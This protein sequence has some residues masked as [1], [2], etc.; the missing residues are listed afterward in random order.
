M[1][2]MVMHKMTEEM[3]KGLPPEPAIIEGVGKLIGEAAKEK[4]FVSG[5]GLK[6]SSQRV[7]IA[8]K[9]GKRT[10]TDGPFTEAKELVAGFALMRVR[11]KQEAIS[12]CDK[13]A[14][15][16]GDVEL[17]M[18]PVVEP[19]DLG[20][21]PKP[22]NPPLRFLSMHKM[23]ERSENEVPPDPQLMAKMGALIDE[24]TKAGV[25]EAT[26]GLASTKKGAR[27]RFKGG[28]HTVIDGPFAE[29]K[30]LVAG[31]ALL[32]LPSKAAAIEWAIRFGDIV[33]VNE[34]EVRQIPEW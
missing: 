5:E 30:E 28:K 8:Y 14:A 13:F 21:V 31:Y 23:D 10:M 6:P 24:M 20:M 3:E 12:W 25:L 15:V 16:L 4:V 1:R 19:W 26:N 29:S 9:N 22:E 2:F 18:G 33:K 11:S 27:I 7:H 34:V 32:D 17:I